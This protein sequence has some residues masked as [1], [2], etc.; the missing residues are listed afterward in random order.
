MR[1]EFRFVGLENT[2]SQTPSTSKVWPS[3]RQEDDR[4]CAW[5][6]YSLVQIFP[7]A[8]HSD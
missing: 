3:D 5:P 1:S 6:F 4:S 7:K 8:L 2:G